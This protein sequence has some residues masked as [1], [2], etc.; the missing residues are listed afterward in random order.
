MSF[1]EETAGRT[2]VGAAGGS[3]RPA[4]ARCAVWTRAHGKDMKLPRC[5]LKKYL[6]TW[7]MRINVSRYSA[8]FEQRNGHTRTVDVASG[9]S[10]R[11]PGGA[12]SHVRLRGRWNRRQRATAVPL[13]PCSRVTCC[14]A[15]RGCTPRCPAKFILQ[16]RPRALRPPRS[17][18]CWTRRRVLVR[19]LRGCLQAW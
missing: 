4:R 8:C 16:P 2:R 14:A 6:M 7:I 17:Q 15:A 9:R 10:R 12:V 5:T 19:K 13:L 18:R 3:R 1:R 11:S